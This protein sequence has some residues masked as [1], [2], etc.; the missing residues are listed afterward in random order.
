[1]YRQTRRR[2]MVEHKEIIHGE[3]SQVRAEYR[4]S[5]SIIHKDRW[6]MK[7]GN[8]YRSVRLMK[9]NEKHDDSGNDGCEFTCQS[10]SSMPRRETIQE[11][12]STVPGFFR[13]GLR[14]GVKV[15]G[16][17]R[18]NRWGRGACIEG[19]RL[20]RRG[21][22]CSIVDFFFPRQTDRPPLL[23]GKLI[24]EDDVPSANVSAPLLS[25]LLYMI[26]H[27][28]MR[29]PEPTTCEFFRT[30]IP[31][32]TTREM[33]PGL[34]M[35]PAS[36]EPTSTTMLLPS[37]PCM[38]CCVSASTS[39]RLI[40]HVVNKLAPSRRKRACGTSSTTKSTSCG[41]SGGARSFPRP[42]NRILVP[43]R[44]PGLTSMS[45]TSYHLSTLNGTT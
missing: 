21:G 18:C 5:E 44:Q 26:A 33:S 19:M 43:F 2:R 25:R 10:C 31:M 34:I 41:A 1:M 17:S 23:H 6:K 37:S 29:S 16:G 12:G 3:T 28:M 30:G 7:R 9:Q 22:S 13:A 42:A 40:S 38:T 15:F 8:R 24:R 36:S 35:P 32:P 11:F 14:R 20:H 27:L 4:E 39:S 45:R